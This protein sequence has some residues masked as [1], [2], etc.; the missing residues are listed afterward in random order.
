MGQL[1]SLDSNKIL[2]YSYN[3]QIFFFIWQAAQV[4][5]MFFVF[6]AA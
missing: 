1:K 4:S 3:L 2:L 6:K 5:K